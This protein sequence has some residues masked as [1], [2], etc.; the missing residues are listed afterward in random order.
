MWWLVQLYTGRAGYQRGVK[1]EGL[2]ASPPVIDCSGWAGLLLTKT[3]QAVEE[4]NS[5]EYERIICERPIVPTLSPD[6][7]L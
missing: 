2:S 6:K 5:R 1:A 7:A 4:R 3:M